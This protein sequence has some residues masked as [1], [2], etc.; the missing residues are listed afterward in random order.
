MTTGAY[1][2]KIDRNKV[3]KTVEHVFGFLG[4]AVVSGMIYLGDRLG[5]YK[6]LEGAGPVTSEELARKTGL[7][8][9]WLREWL[10]GQATAGLLDYKGDGRF[11]LSPETA[12]VLA[13]ESSSAFAAG[14]FCALPQQMAVLEQLP[15]SFKTGLGLPYDALGPEGARG[16]ERMAAPWFRAHLVPKVLPQLDGVVA[17]LEAGA[18]VADVGCGAGAAMIEVAKAYPHSQFHGYDIS[19]HALERAEENKAQAG[20]RNVTFHNAAV[21]PLPQDASFD[22][23]TTFDCLHDMAHPSPV[24]QAIYK[25][26]KRDGVWLIADINSLP[27]FEENLSNNPFAHM[28]YGFSVLCCMSSALSEPGGAGLGTLGF[29]EP[30][31]H[32]MVTDAGFTHFRRLDFNNPINAYYEVRP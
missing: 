31:A 23:I 11:E 12:L 28:W 27:T 14:G 19:Q 9:R 3:K 26:L 18:K 7:H 6:A 17:K 22:F 32:K 16:V 25:A 21:D 30:V 1:D 29:T 5:L 2:Q 13:N 24:I 10:Q 4:G 20:V 8:E 15:E